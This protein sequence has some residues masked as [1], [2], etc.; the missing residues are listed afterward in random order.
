METNSGK[1]AALSTDFHQLWPAV[2]HTESCIFEYWST[3]STQIIHKLIL[4]L[5]LL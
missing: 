3:Q 4:A 5:I 2:G 1:T